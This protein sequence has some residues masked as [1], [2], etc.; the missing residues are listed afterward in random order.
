M[1]QIVK[2]KANFLINISHIHYYIFELH[3]LLNAQICYPNFI[4]NIIIN[5]FLYNLIY[6]KILKHV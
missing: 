2:K 4:F 1:F 5:L 6:F 3:Y